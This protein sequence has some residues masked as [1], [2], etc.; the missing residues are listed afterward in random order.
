MTGKRTELEEWAR[1]RRLEIVSSSEFP[2]KLT[3]LRA[4][5]AA[6]KLITTQPSSA[7]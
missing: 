3:V 4:F 2:E 7:N 6:L 1:L 5:D